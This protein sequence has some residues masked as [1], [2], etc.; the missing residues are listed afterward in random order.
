MTKDLNYN[1]IIICEHSETGEL[2]TL[3][4]RENISYDIINPIGVNA[5]NKYLDRKLRKGKYRH[6]KGG[7]Y[8]LLTVGQHKGEP[9]AIY[10]TTVDNK[11]YAR[12]LNM[13]VSQVDKEKYPDVKQKYRF[14]EVNR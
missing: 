5:V 6:F 1:E 7:E 11:C 12:P 14:E 2:M 10:E 8:N 4:N 9:Y 3:I 13:F